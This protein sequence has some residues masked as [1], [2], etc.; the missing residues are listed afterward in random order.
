MRCCGVRLPPV[1]DGQDCLDSGDVV[2]RAKVGGRPELARDAGWP[3]GHDEGVL[4]GVAQTRS[5][6]P[7]L[8]HGIDRIELLN[9]R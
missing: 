7:P 4:V 6:Q 3:G 1:G 5:V 9:G 2:R 8:K